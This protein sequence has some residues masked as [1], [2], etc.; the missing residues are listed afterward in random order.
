M[1]PGVWLKLATLMFLQ[2]FVWGAWSVTMGTWL[3]QTLGFSGAQIGLAFGTTAVAA[4]VSPF[5]VGMVADRFLATQQILAALHVIGGVILLAASYQTT[6]GPF[7]AVLLAYALCYMPTLALSNS[8]SFRQMKDP[9]SEFPGIRVLGT[10]GWIVAGL[11]IGTMGLEATAMPM[12][13]AAVASGLLGLFCVALPHTPPQA[14]TRA[15]MSDIL[16]L[17]ALKLMKDRAFAVFVIGS[18][19]VCIPL[20]FYYT[21]ANPFLNEIQVSNAAGKM[22]LGQ[23]SEIFFMIAMPWFFR[24]LGVKKM[25]LVGMAAW[26]ARYVL[27]AFGAEGPVVWMLYGGILLHG[28]CYD[29][30]CVTGQI[31]VDRTAPS[32]LRA[33][34]QGFIAFVTLGA[35]MFIGSLVSGRIVDAFATPGGHAWDQIWLV[36]AAGAAA[37]LLLFALFFRGETRPDR[38]NVVAGFSRIEP[39]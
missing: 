14:T 28:I 17:D 2:Y 4:M 31:Y 3:G 9:G 10:I 34:A 32:H 30:F 1:A 19:L 22:T 35:G 8:L 27:F 24:R 6:F 37:V 16:G 15:S 12:R 18:F 36:P 20:Q 21:F 13:I 5:F 39:T 11:V 38:T 25:L 29:F 26:T 7:Y 23:M 33:S